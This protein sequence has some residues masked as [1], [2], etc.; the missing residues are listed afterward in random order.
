MR[1]FEEKVTGKRLFYGLTNE[2]PTFS[3]HA[4]KFASSDDY[5]SEERV[6]IKP[7]DL[8][9]EPC[10]AIQVLQRFKTAFSFLLV[11]KTPH[12]WN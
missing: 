7:E 8:P 12:T 9:E 4:A 3:T 2:C 10:L 1:C 5:I 6:V 11:L